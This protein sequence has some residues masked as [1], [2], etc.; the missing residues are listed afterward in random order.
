MK[1][2]YPDLHVDFQRGTNTVR[3]LLPPHHP[4]IAEKDLPPSWIWM[5]NNDW[6][7]IY[8][9]WSPGPLP[10]VVPSDL[11]ANIPWLAHVPGARR[12]MMR[13]VMFPGYQTE[14]PS[15]SQ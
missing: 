1:S 12:R 7:Q 2:T 10:K 14:K 6:I 5:R 8:I 4:D 13:T 3:I 11:R 15:M 9:G